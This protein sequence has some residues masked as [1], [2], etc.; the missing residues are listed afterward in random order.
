M[1]GGAVSLT[2]PKEILAEYPVALPRVLA[3][4]AGER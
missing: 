2:R 1:F 3:G 4:G